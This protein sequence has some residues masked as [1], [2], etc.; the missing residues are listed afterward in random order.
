MLRMR[1]TGEKSDSV[2]DEGVVRFMQEK[3]GRDHMGLDNNQ[4]IILETL[5]RN[6]AGR[7]TSLNALA[8]VTGLDRSAIES[9]FE[10]LLVRFGLMRRGSGGREITDKGRSHLRQSAAA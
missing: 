6:P 3:T 5:E 10:P 1:E 2:V 7:K 8:D 4:R 9:S